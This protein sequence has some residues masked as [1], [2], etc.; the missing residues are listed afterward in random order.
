MQSYHLE[1][2]ISEQPEMLRNTYPSWEKQGKEYYDKFKDREQLVVI[3]RVARVMLVL[4]PR[5]FGA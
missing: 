4:S 5:I 1:R 3:G 2:E